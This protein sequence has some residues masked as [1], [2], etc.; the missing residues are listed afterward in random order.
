MPRKKQSLDKSTLDFNKIEAP[1]SPKL[2]DEVYEQK[3]HVKETIK[4]FTDMVIPRGI[5]VKVYG[6]EYHKN[7]LI[8]GCLVKVFCT[9]RNPDELCKRESSELNDYIN[10]SLNIIR[11]NPE[12]LNDV[13][14]AYY[15][16]ITKVTEANADRAFNLAEGE[17]GEV[18]GQI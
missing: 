7:R 4:D 9:Y 8:E 2:S 3:L 10:K 17:D 5:N 15:K 18:Y 6:H 1:D 12:E 14:K 16:I 11:E 13:G